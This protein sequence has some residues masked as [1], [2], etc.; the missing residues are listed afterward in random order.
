MSTRGRIL[1]ADR[2]FCAWFRAQ[3]ELDS[4]QVGIGMSDTDV[5]IHRYKTPEQGRY[6]QYLM[7]V[8]VKAR[9]GTIPPSQ[10]DTL[11]KLHAF[12][13]DSV[14]NG[15]MIKFL[16]V[17]FLRFDGTNPDDSRSIEWGEFEEL[18]CEV[19]WRE[20]TLDE[21]FSLLRFDH[22]DAHR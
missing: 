21:L 17:F 10:K 18:R 14:V 4:Q 9:S 19:S 20:I 7:Q 2:P 13:A 12:R 5:L 16:G 11:W 1:G 8:E 22:V 15:Q 6:V 3:A